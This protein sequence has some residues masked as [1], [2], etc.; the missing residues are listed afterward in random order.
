MNNQK[1]TILVTGGAGFIGSHVAEELI[2]AGHKVIVFDD[3]SG[4]FL[5]NV[6]KGA[7]FIQG[8]TS[9]DAEVKKLFEKYQFDYIFHLA[10][11]AAEGL[12]FFIK[13]FNYK[14]NLISSI[15]LINA[16]V[17][18]GVKCFV[19]TSSI[20]V[21]GNQ[22]PPFSEDNTP[23]P[24]DPYAISKFAV[25]MDLK[26]SNDMWGL[27]Y[28]IFRP[29]NVYGEKQ[30]IGDKYRN[31][32]GIFMNQIMEGKELTIFGDG[33][34]TRAF[35]YIK[36]ISPVIANSI[37]N[38]DAYNQ[39]FNIGSDKEYTVKELAEI[40]NNSMDSR[41]EIK[42]LDARNEVVNAYSKIDKAKEIFG[43]SL[44]TNLETGVNKMADWAKKAGSKKSKEFENIEVT[45]NMPKSW[46]TK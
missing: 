39:I 25:E 10:A 16:A 14:N 40:V 38:Q 21:Y 11:Y 44:K 41:N 45:K 28:I 36:D 27:N 35:T 31:V 18:S 33:M 26:I 17:N 34:Q 5:E 29:Y 8:D 12:S 13:K 24:K 7:E 15:N 9:S 37:F 22:T 19:F 32:I 46:L 23:T 1:Y 30:N 4:G 20:A 6:P 2:Q 42:Y 3:L 43:Y